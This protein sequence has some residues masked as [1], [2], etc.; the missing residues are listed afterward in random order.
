MP[1]L[2]KALQEAPPE[3]KRQVFE[4]FGLRIAY[5]KVDRRIEI[6]VTISETVAKALENAK[7]LP[8]KVSSV[9]PRDIAGARFVPQSDAQVT[10]QYRLAA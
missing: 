10:Q 2:S 7:D 5:D 4:A 8:E 1:D 3:L 9:A 6:S